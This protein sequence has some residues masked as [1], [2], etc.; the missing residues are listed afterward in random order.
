MPGPGRGCGL[1]LRGG[2][3]GRM[4]PV[5]PAP[6]AV[7]GPGWAAGPGHSILGFEP[8]DTTR[9]CGVRPGL[10]IES[11]PPAAG[12]SARARAFPRT[13]EGSLPGRK[14]EAPTEASPL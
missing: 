1:P 2:Q 8:P 7:A 10:R 14:R 13:P 9:C 6:E 11:D 4:L 5:P 3:S 12:V